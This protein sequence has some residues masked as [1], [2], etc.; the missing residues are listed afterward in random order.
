MTKIQ[1][2]IFIQQTALF[3]ELLSHIWKKKIRIQ[4]PV[5]YCCQEQVKLPQMDPAGASPFKNTL[6]DG[7]WVGFCLTL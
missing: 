3:C 6:L 7:H 5:D 1:S 4:I 2:V